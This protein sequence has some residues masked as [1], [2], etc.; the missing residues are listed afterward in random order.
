MLRSRA[1]WSRG[2]PASS[3]DC[4]IQPRAQSREGQVADPRRGQFDRQRQAVQLLTDCGDVGHVGLGQGEVVSRG[5][6]PVQEEPDSR[7]LPHLIDRVEA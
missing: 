5:G 2:P 7:H 3:A 4:T 1:G 6:R